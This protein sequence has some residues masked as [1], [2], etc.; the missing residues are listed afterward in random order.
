ML[1]G[2]ID[3]PDVQ[4]FCYGLRAGRS[5]HQAL[6][7]LREQCLGKNSHWIIDADISGFFA[8]LDHDLLREAIRHRVNEGSILRLIGRGLTA[9]VSDGG[10][11]TYPETG[12]PQGGVLSPVLRNIL[13]HDVLDEWLVRDGQPRMQGRCCLLC[14]A[15]EFVLGC[16]V[17]EDARRIMAV[18]PKRF[19][20]FRLT[21][22]PQ[23][24]RR[25]GFRKPAR[26]ETADKGNGTCEFLGFTQYW[27]TSRLGTWV[28][29]R[30]TAQKRVRRAQQ[31][32]WQWCRHHR[33]RPLKE[34]D[35]ALCQKGTRPLPVLCHAG[36]L[37]SPGVA[38]GERAQGV[39]L[40]AEP[41]GPREL[42]PVG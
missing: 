30:T 3:E 5:P 12:S 33:H 42:Y 24:T 34:Q 20:R 40:L 35:Q 18:L 9:G 31:A 13:L 1:L 36:E 26:R 21:I 28:R 8:S 25:M 2:A 32:L 41:P 16:E 37:P 10:D 7:A 4:D 14:C 17:A 38:L 6:T 39:A 15:D 22:H 23:K 27:A 11:R 29:K 19:A